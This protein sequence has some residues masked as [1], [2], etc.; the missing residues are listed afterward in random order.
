VSKI[1]IVD[2]E[3]NVRKIL[4]IQLRRLGHDTLEAP[5]GPEALDL[6]EKTNVQAVVT[7][8]K[9]PKMD[10]LELLQKI[11]KTYPQIPVIMITAHGT[12]DTAVEAM[13][14][15]AF[16][17]VTKPFNQDEFYKIIE[18]AIRSSEELAKEFQRSRNFLL[19]E[20]KIIGTTE[21]MEKV[22]TIIE[23]VANNN[24]N[25]L[26]TGETGTGKEVVVRLLHDKSLRKDKPL[27]RAYMSA[28]REEQQYGQLFGE[29]KKPGCFE[30]ASD[31]SLYIDEVSILT[32]EVQAKLYE[33]LTAGTYS[34][35][36]KKRKIECRIIAATDFNLLE[37]IENGEFRKDLFYCLNVVP[38]YL[39]PLRE[40]TQDIEPLVD[41]FIRIFSKK[42]QKTISHMDEEAFFHLIE[43]DWPGNL[44]ELENTI[45][46]A[47]N[48][49]DVP[50]L[51]TQHLPPHL[52]QGDR[53]IG[54]RPG[55]SSKD[56]LSAKVQGLERDAIEEAIRSSAG[57]LL[58]ASQK[59]GVP[60]SLLEEKLARLQ[61]V[62]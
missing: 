43:Y 3:E 4:G 36:G 27:V 10:G 13:K 48:V 18:R 8:L 56:Y 46:Y 50:V 40:R 60:P 59:L 33:A 34:A 47:V 2:D 16:D 32:L 51:N 57:D 28:C 52:R 12:I 41:H 23:H 53:L 20:D 61:I 45:E 55:E 7:D 31:G 9:M 1:L 14:R 39:P 49:S 35:D 42:F 26:I 54:L 24:S 19:Q 29:D 30:L 62:L 11:R 37:K 5:D 21:E 6:L 25:V 22:Y 15:G 38:I 58:K 17:Y 44:R